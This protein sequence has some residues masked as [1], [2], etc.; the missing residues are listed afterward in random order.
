MTFRFYRNATNLQVAWRLALQL[1]DACVCTLQHKYS[2]KT[3][4]IVR[5]VPQFVGHFEHIGRVASFFNHQ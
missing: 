4:E 2:G 5:V 1:Y 3:S